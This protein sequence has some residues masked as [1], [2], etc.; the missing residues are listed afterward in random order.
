VGMIE[1]PGQVVGFGDLLYSGFHYQFDVFGSDST[2]HTLDNPR[3]MI[4]SKRGKLL[5]SDDDGAGTREPR[6][7]F[8]PSQ[9]RPYGFS[10]DGVDGSTGTFRL[11]W[12]IASI[13]RAVIATKPHI[14]IG[15]H[16]FAARPDNELFTLNLIKGKW[17]HVNF[18]GHPWQGSV[19]VELLSPIGNRQT[20]FH[21]EAYY[22]DPNDPGPE[23]PDNQIGEARFLAQS[24][25]T[26]FLTS[27]NARRNWIFI[28]EST[29]PQ[30]ET[31]RFYGTGEMGLKAHELFSTSLGDDEKIQMLDFNFSLMTAASLRIDGQLVLPSTI[32]DRPLT[33]AFRFE[34]DPVVASGSY[35]AL[36][37]R[38]KSGNSRTPWERIEIYQPFDLNPAKFD[39]EI[40]GTAQQHRITFVANKRVLLGSEST[41]LGLDASAEFTPVYANLH[42]GQESRLGDN[43]SITTKLGTAF[44]RVF[45]GSADDRLIG[46]EQENRLFGN[47]GNDFIAG[48]QGDDILFGGEGNDRYI[49]WLGDGRDVIDEQNHGGRDSLQLNCP[50]G[51]K[52][53]KEDLTFR[54]VGDD[55]HISLDFNRDSSVRQGQMI[56]KNMADPASQVESLRISS[57]VDLNPL[58]KLVNLVSVW[59]SL[60]SSV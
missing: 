19:Q 48:G 42:A 4:Y 8:N 6:I 13:D 33:S 46:N 47:R 52:N 10:V 49:Y 36:F 34:F 56:I 37:V 9:S 39:L 25:G 17:Y 24:T 14:E 31:P 22:V 57:S 55:L 35:D 7:F 58:G 54:R 30:L 44:Y 51:L 11:K 23:P 41:F 1:S 28:D 40:N 26:F 3:L 59:Q 12:R 29:S 16:F 32:Y 5:A 27:S 20:R 38:Q 15:Q 45:G 50:L 2:T 43:A 21:T 18:E 53:A 60:A